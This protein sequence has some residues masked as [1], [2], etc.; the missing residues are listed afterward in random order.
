[1]LFTDRRGLRHWN[2]DGDEE[3]DCAPG[4]GGDYGGR[5]AGNLFDDYDD[6][7]NHNSGSIWD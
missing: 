7:T 5:H 3:D 4:L 2:P 6:D 1:M